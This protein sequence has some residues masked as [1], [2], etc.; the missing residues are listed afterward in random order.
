[1][2]ETATL[3][4]VFIVGIVT[5]F[6]DSVIGAGGLISVPSLVFLGLPLQV[7]IATDRF[8]TI[9]Q[10]VAAF[11]KFWKGKKIVWRYVVILSVISLA[12][13][14]IGAQMLVHTSTDILQKVVG[15]LLIIL[16]PL[17]FLKQ[18]IGTQEHETGR[19]KKQQGYCYTLLL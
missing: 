19:L 18:N 5:G 17:I 12:G 4:L 9:G 16:L 6:F 11:I 14:L 15:V 2:P 7:A 1:M 3:L 8:G 13:S 10:S